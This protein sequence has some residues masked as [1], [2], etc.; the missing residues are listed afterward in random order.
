VP[1]VPVFEVGVV[2]AVVWVMAFRDFQWATLFSGSPC[3]RVS[4]LPNLENASIL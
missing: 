1:W 4:A 3:G 2:V